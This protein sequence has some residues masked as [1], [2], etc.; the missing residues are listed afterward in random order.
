MVCRTVF[1]LT[2]AVG[3]GR[4]CHPIFGQVSVIPFSGKRKPTSL[5]GG[6]RLHVHHQSRHW[7]NEPLPIKKHMETKCQWCVKNSG[8][9]SKTFSHHLP[10]SVISKEITKNIKKL[11]FSR[12]LPA[13]ASYEPRWSVVVALQTHHPPWLAWPRGGAG[14]SLT[15]AIHGW[16]IYLHGWWKWPDSMGNVCKYSPTWILRV[17]SLKTLTHPQ[18]LYIEK[19]DVGVAVPSLNYPFLGCNT[20]DLWKR[21]VPLRSVGCQLEWHLL[22]FTLQVSGNQY[23]C[24]TS[25]KCAR[26]IPNRELLIVLCGPFRVNQETVSLRGFCLPSKPCQLAAPSWTVVNSLP[27]GLGPLDPA[28]TNS[29]ICVFSFL[30]KVHP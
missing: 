1:N 10:L 4:A 14:N 30:P 29:Q 12:C 8:N 23:T 2:A 22:F 7:Q 15:H 24:S 9:S 11:R 20:F 13:L 18:T 25:M 3:K 21:P 28:P 26:F 19:F 5:P 6:Y 27:N 17:K 16:I